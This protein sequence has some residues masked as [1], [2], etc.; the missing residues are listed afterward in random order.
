[1]D[2]KVDNL[3]VKLF[4]FFGPIGSLIPI[5]SIKAFRFYYFIIIL[6]IIY[7]FLNYNKN[8]PA[9]KTMLYA[10]PIILLII[11][12]SMIAYLNTVSNIEAE[13]PVIRAILVISLFLFTV[14]IG[15]K[16]KY[17]SNE[18][19][20]KYIF[21]Y[22][23]GYL[24]SLVFG[25]IFFIG[26][27]MNFI[28]L[29]TISSFQV[30]TQIGYG[31]LRFSPGSYPN[32]YGIVSSYV[33]SLIT[34]L[35]LRRKEIK[36]ISIG[37]SR[38]FLLILFLLVL[39]ALFLTTTR[40]AYLSYVFVV[41]YLCV[42]KGSLVNKFKKLFIVI[43]SFTIL[44]VIVQI[45]FFDIYGMFETAYTSFSNEDASAYERFFAWQNAYKDFLDNYILGVGFGTI[46]GIHNTYL[47]FIFEFGL[48]GSL[49]F[50]IYI[51]IL[52]YKLLYILKHHKKDFLYD[53]CVIGL[54][55]ILWFAMSNHNLNHHLTWF[56]IFTIYMLNNNKLKRKMYF[57]N[58][59]GM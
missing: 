30:L 15:N 51:L 54:I 56:V 18:K 58:S 20:I 1:M 25:Y 36:I 22:L 5:V 50:G 17:I 13:N 38:I 26:Y 31:L 32:E 35:I 57:E 21:I 19:K 2:N 52:L 23:L 41:F 8:K 6:G 55:H 46:S 11:T 12:S 34:L 27:D 3:F 42:L 4:C 16:V 40:A 33:L 29:E 39:I 28:S 59:S 48:F 7:F 53:V 47:Q 44:G 37:S 10:Y 43:G 45:Y 9:I 24:V 49:L 14:F